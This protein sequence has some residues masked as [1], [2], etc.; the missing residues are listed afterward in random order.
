MG[1]NNKGFS[2]V[3]LIVALAIFGVAGVAVF[4]FMVNSS[5]LYQR[6]NVDVKLQYEQQLAVNQIRDMVVESDKG[7]YFDDTSKTLAL[8]GAMKNVSGVKSY[9]VTVIRYVESEQRLYYGVKEFS[10]VTEITFA[11]VTTDKLLAENVKKFNVD[12][13][14]VKN[15]K[16]FFE[17]VFIV[18]DR[19][20]QVKETVALRNRLIV[21]NQVDTIWGDEPVVIESFIQKVAIKRDG[22]E[23]ADGEQDTIG[24]FGSSVTVA[25]SAEVSANE[26]S[27]RAYS[28]AVSWSIEE[29]EGVMVDADG[30]V[31]VAS[32]VPN[33]TKFKLYA[34]SVD[35][36]SKST[37]IE[38]MVT[39]S[40]VY[41]VDVTLAC[42][43][44]KRTDGNGFRTYKLVP[45]VTYSDG[46]TSSD[47][48]LF[49]WDGIDSLPDGATFKKEM[50]ELTLGAN[51]NG[52]SI[53]I[54]AKAKERKADGTVAYGEYTIVVDGIEE[55]VPGPSIKINCSPSLSRG[56]YVFPSL[57]FE[58]ATHSN[59]KYNWKV[60]PYYDEETTPFDGGVSNDSFNFISMGISASSAGS[61]NHELSTNA[62]RRSV[63]LCCAQQLNW[64]KTFKVKVSATATDTEGNTVV[65]TPKIVTIAPVEVTLTCV[66]LA[67]EHNQYQGYPC[68]TNTEICYE[69]WNFDGRQPGNIWASQ[70]DMRRWFCIDYTNLYMEGNWL[71]GCYFQYNFAFKN[72]GGEQLINSNVGEPTTQIYNGNMRYCGFM[73]QKF[74]DWETK[75][76]RPV[77]MSF[78]LT[79]KDYNGN[80][81][82]SNR[83][84]FRLVY[85]WRVLD[86]LKENQ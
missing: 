36:P 7:I 50:G 40:G 13:T 17:V 14:K 61:G 55:F 85:E 48:D 26:E 15:D 3:E 68:V 47:Y 23:F 58:N 65:A 84:D 45:T 19:E 73:K 67:K 41:P 9:P 81:V 27:D 49:I 38:I 12:L 31:T 30:K 60:E 44:D 10:A 6:S 69:D 59:Y 74:N 77:D 52:Y 21:S 5:R 78:S 43:E 1:R 51:A 22:R 33:N 54:K 28:F 24:K 46:H 79:L 29:T 8:Y 80:V 37:F 20:Q 66:D 34:T 82:E 25:Y 2:L 76:N 71:N 11:D 86:D 4:G 53:T 18:G 32:T 39:E 63:A 75:D 70:Y 62:N 16:V 56:G 35:D 72:S 64:N 42:P 57:T 83:N